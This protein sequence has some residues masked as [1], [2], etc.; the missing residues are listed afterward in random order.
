[1]T[2]PPLFG[3]EDIGVLLM[4]YGDTQVKNG[5]SR[6][7]AGIIFELLAD[8]AVE[9]GG[10]LVLELGSLEGRGDT[11]RFVKRHGQW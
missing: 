9:A 10:C 7:N 5:A 6:F 3:F 4:T 11:R 8:L 2:G 1:M